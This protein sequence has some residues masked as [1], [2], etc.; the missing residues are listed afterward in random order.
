M[1]LSSQFQG[2]CRD[3]HS[4]C[5]DHIAR[6]TQPPSLYSI[7]HAEFNLARRLDRGNPNAGN[8][9]ADFARLGLAFWQEVSKHDARNATRQAKLHELN[10]WR[11]AIA[12]QDFDPQT[13]KP[14]T[15]TLPVVKGWRSS[16]DALAKSFDVVMADYITATVGQRPW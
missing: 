5:V 13:L 16:C 11:N 6:A 9:G 7:L 15:L 8:I 10:T 3:L 4:E 1:L 14:V 12:H 2:F